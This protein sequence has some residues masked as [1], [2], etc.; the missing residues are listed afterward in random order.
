MCNERRSIRTGF[1]GRLM[2]IFIY[3]L[4]VWC[5]CGCGWT[6]DTTD[7]LVTLVCECA[8]KGVFFCFT[9]WFLIVEIINFF[10]LLRLLRVVCLYTGGLWY[11]RTFEDVYDPYDRDIFFLFVVNYDDRSIYKSN[12]SNYMNLEILNYHLHIDHSINSHEILSALVENKAQNH[13]NHRRH[14]RAKPNTS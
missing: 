9:F 14:L 12:R 7:V 1:A 11:F 2:F 8:S 10:F 5:V 6:H 3:I 13:N 4:G